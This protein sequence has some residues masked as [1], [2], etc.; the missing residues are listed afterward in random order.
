MLI[1]S[2]KDTSC[3]E[4]EAIVNNISTGGDETLSEEVNKN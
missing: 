1:K 3:I 4:D 2:I